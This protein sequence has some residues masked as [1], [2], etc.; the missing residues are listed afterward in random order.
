MSRN[1]KFSDK[2]KLQRIFLQGRNRG[3]AAA[4]RRMR[5]ERDQED[6]EREAEQPRHDDDDE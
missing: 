3:Q 2:K 6:S 4:H 1:L 5:E